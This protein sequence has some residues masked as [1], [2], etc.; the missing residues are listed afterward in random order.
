[1]KKTT[2]LMVLLVCLFQWSGQWDLKAQVRNIG[3]THPRHELPV[4]W[5]CTEILWSSEDAP[6]DQL[7]RIEVST[8]A[9]GSWEEINFFGTHEEES[10]RLI[11]ND[12]HIIFS[13]PQVWT[14]YALIR[15]SDFYNP[16]DYKLSEMFTITSPIPEE[17]NLTHP[18]PEDTF[19]AGTSM[20]IRWDAVYLDGR[21]H[22]YMSQYKVRIEYSLQ[23]YGDWNLIEKFA[24]ND[25]L[26][27]WRIPVDVVSDDCYVRISHIENGFSFIS[28]VGPVTIKPLPWNGYFMDVS[29]ASGVNLTGAYRCVSWID[30]NNNGWL[31]L[32]VTGS[33]GYPNVLYLNNGNGTFTRAPLQPEVEDAA[34]NYRACVFGD[35]DND[36]QPDLYLGGGN[37]TSDKLF[38]NTGNQTFTDITTQAGIESY[39]EEANGV[40][41]LDYNLDGYLDIYVCMNGIQNHLYHNNG[42]ATFTDMTTPA[43][44]EGGFEGHS[45]AVAVGDY[46]RDGDPDMYVVNS[47]NEGNILYR[48]NGNGTF[49][50]GTQFDMGLA[51]S[52]CKTAEWGD[53]NTDGLL[54]LY[55]TRRYDTNLLFQYNYDGTFTEVTEQARV[56]EEGES[57]VMATGDF[58]SDG[59]LD[60]CVGNRGANGTEKILLYMN[61]GEDSFDEL[62]DLSGL[63]P[64]NEPRGMAAGDY[65]KDGDLDLFVANWGGVSRLFENKL[66]DEN[67]NHWVKVQLE[68]VNSNRDAIGSRVMI[69][70]GNNWQRRDVQVGTGYGNSNSLEVEFGLGGY[71]S[72]ESMSIYWPS[73]KRHIFSS[74]PSDSVYYIKEVPDSVLEA[75]EGTLTITSPDTGMV[76]QSGTPVQIL[77]EST[78]N[79]DSVQLEYT[80]DSGENWN[81]VTTTMN[82]GAFDW[83]IPLSV[84]GD[85]CRVRI[86]D[87]D[88]G[89]PSDTSN[90]FSVEL[91]TIPLHWEVSD[92]VQEVGVPFW[93]NL[94]LGDESH[95]VFS[96]KNMRAEIRFSLPDYMAIVTDSIELGRVWGINPLTS[97]H[98]D[99]M[100]GKVS[101]ELQR[102]AFEGGFNGYGP[103]IRVQFVA[104][105]HTPDST[106]FIIQLDSLIMTDMAGFVLPGEISVLTLTLVNA[107]LRVWPGDTN[108]DG[109]VNHE[110]I[111]PMGFYWGLEGLS[112]ND[113]SGQ[114]TAQ[115]SVPWTT[116]NATYSDGN[117][118]GHIDGDDLLLIHQNW[119]REHEKSAPT[120]PMGENPSNVKINVRVWEHKPYQPFC[121]GLEVDEG[122][123]LFGASL[124]FYYDAELIEIDS[125]E[126]GPLWGSETVFLCHDDPSIGEVSIGISQ[127]A[128]QE[129]NEDSGTLLKVWMKLKDGV[130]L[131]T[132]VIFK[133]DDVTAINSKGE[134][135][136]VTIENS[137][138]VTDVDA[139]IMEMPAVFRLYPN[140][141]NPFNPMTII[142]YDL[143]KDC[144]VILHIYDTRGQEVRSLIDERQERG[145][146][147][148]EW[149]GKDN[150]GLRVSSG[151]YMYRIMAGKNT[152]TRKCILMK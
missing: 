116:E 130:A 72:V 144:R 95:P 61:T 4:N 83:S 17:L 143:P 85:S 70:S 127:K 43:G 22:Y 78:G 111:L 74:L 23:K 94:S 11:Y 55:V 65:D 63:I 12:G 20:E 120:L 64:V 2:L 123:S 82:N 105:K 71:Q 75:E 121:T 112:R 100:E 81:L 36:G 18:K 47:G 124:T 133:I 80:V 54:D 135:L 58:D 129:R 52:N 152:S 69:F 7:L 145:Y 109:I 56:G 90:V 122:D 28:T 68:G 97:I 1:M 66:V 91:V 39:S 25:G 8:D 33:D 106:E 146:R 92:T 115:R 6:S 40:A 134:S 42:D 44:V 88:D 27:I 103:V 89:V 30:M 117:G 9:G 41:F 128:G 45:A 86:T 98:V 126:S 139:T 149:D 38:L 57:V 137:G 93:A 131:N 96:M 114:W 48:N 15:I 67:G 142:S 60:M 119:G 136:T 29:S 76:F 31:D 50:D 46:D 104:R 140:Y 21:V 87:A 138:Y 53:F 110:D 13:P 5:S 37:N 99:S 148:V 32:F 51:W 118:D 16:N 102:S 3:I 26:F 73:G 108:N 19:V 132:P 59:R 35:I 125:V 14:H 77:W 141:P 34:S 24:A 113:G 84:S 150:R 79:I 151:I 101:M 49:S 62:S 147:T 107:G 10:S